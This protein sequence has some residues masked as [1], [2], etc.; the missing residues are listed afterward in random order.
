MPPPELEHP[1]SVSAKMEVSA[2]SGRCRVFMGFSSVWDV[3]AAQPT[4]SPPC[5]ALRKACARVPRMRPGAIEDVR[6]GQR[7]LR[8]QLL[9]LPSW[10]DRVKLVRAFSG[11]GPG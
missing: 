8:G 1:T 4:T 3:V 9:V 2:T 6:R 11:A 5:S 7:M 10:Q